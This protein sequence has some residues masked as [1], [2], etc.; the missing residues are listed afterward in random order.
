M[1]VDHRL[2]DVDG[3][4]LAA[5]FDFPRSCQ[6]GLV[7]AGDKCTADGRIADGSGLVTEID[8]AVVD[9]QLVW[10]DQVWGCGM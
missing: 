2:V 10:L 4:G 8:F 5:G 7:G 1:D 6:D 3:S 9:A